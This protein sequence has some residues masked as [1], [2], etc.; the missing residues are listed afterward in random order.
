MRTVF[1]IV[2]G[3]ALLLAAGALVRGIGPDAD[4]EQ[5]PPHSLQTN[6]PD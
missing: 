3:I 6:P 2:I 5:S 1:M 4:N